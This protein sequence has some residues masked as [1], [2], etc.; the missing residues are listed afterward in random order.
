MCWWLRRRVEFD[1]IIGFRAEIEVADPSYLVEDLVVRFPLD[2]KPR[3]ELSLITFIGVW[4]PILVNLF[5]EMPFLCFEYDLLGDFIT[6][7]IGESSS[8]SF[9]NNCRS[10]EPMNGDWWELFT[11]LSNILG[12][13]L[14]Y[15]ILGLIVFLDIVLA[16]NLDDISLEVCIFLPFIIVSQIHSRDYWDWIIL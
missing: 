8:T 9:L 11:W 13:V 3:F 16:F 14:E 6:S 10:W 1:G 2:R 4:G 12:E 5:G 15:T 7:L